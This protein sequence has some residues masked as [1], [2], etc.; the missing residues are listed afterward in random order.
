MGSQSS[1]WAKIKNRRERKEKMKN[2]PEEKWGE[3]TRS[4]AE[5]PQ[6]LLPSASGVLPAHMNTSFSSTCTVFKMSLR[7]AQAVS[8]YGHNVVA[9]HFGSRCC[10]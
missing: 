4:T 1:F 5:H 2:F 6:I 10:N 8:F 3:V 7:D 9:A